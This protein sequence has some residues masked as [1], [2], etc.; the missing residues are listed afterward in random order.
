MLPAG[1]VGLFCAI[2]MAALISSHNGFMHAWGGVLLQDI[3]LPFR[4]RPLSTRSHIWALRGSITLVGFVAFLL[5]IS[6]NPQQSILM[7]FAAVNSIW[8]GPA[9]AVMLGGLYWKRGTTAAAMSTLIA[10]SVVGMI[11]FVLQQGWPVWYQKAEFPINGQYC[12]LINI[13]FSILLYVG[14]SLLTCTES[15]N[16]ERMLHRGPYAAAGEVLPELR[17]TRWW[18]SVFGITPMFNRRDRITAYIIVGWFLFWLGTFIAG[19]TYGY[20]ANPRDELW[21][22]FW[23]VYLCLNFAVLVG[24]TLWLGIGGIKDVLAL[25]KTMRGADRDF[26]DTGET[27]P[28]TP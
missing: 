11:F 10:G 7:L 1:L 28:D 19:M 18:Q 26:S 13:A 25:F 3:I 24:T 20:L 17:P 23:L 6:F 27:T 15:F 22:D 16:M 5:S 12:F 21:V 14:I 4:K 9:G 2:M 8:L